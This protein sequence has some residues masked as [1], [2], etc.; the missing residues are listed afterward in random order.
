M[1]RGKVRPKGQVQYRKLGGGSFLMEKRIIKPGQIFWA[2]PSDIPEAFEDRIELI[3][4]EKTQ[5]IVRAAE[6]VARSVYKLV[7]TKGG[8]YNIVC[9]SRA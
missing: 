8:K 4:P 2:F 5:A 1:E 9:S 7:P 3:D 6:N